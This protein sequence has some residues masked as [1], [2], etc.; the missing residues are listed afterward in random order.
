MPSFTYLIKNT[1]RLGRKSFYYAKTYYLKKQKRRVYEQE[2][3]EMQPPNRREVWKDSNTFKKKKEKFLGFR[4]AKRTYF[5]R[6]RIAD[7]EL[8][9]RGRTIST[10]TNTDS[11]YTLK[12]REPQGRHFFECCNFID[13]NRSN[14]NVQKCRLQSIGIEWLEFIASCNLL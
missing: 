7:T 4:D 6:I 12:R 8:W 14:G 5:C 3:R 2:K 1:A 11:R 13:S 10:C 9:I